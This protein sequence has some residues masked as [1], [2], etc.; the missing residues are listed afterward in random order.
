[1]F[2]QMLESIINE[3]D[4][5][6][7]ELESI[8]KRLG[9]CEENGGKDFADEINTVV[10][11]TIDGLSREFLHDSTIGI[12]I[13]QEVNEALNS[14]IEIQVNDYHY[15]KKYCKRDNIDFFDGE[16]EGDDWNEFG[17]STKDLL[18]KVYGAKINFLKNSFAEEIKSKKREYQ[19]Y[20]TDFSIVNKALN[21]NKL[22]NKIDI[23]T[24]GNFELREMLGWMQ[25]LT[26]SINEFFE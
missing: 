23:L 12:L 8:K 19:K 2:R 26:N 18:L 13:E 17:I 22:V 21:V 5:I 25:I 15:L 10:K 3:E 7:Q 1:M 6:L 11:N 16:L 9:A 20:M 14:E 4:R 24:K